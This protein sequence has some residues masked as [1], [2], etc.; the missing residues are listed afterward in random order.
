MVPCP[1]LPFSLFT[2]PSLTPCPSPSLYL[3][4]VPLPCMYAC[5]SVS[6]VFSLSLCLPPLSVSLSVLSPLFP[7]R[8]P[9]LL[10]HTSMSIGPL[11]KVCRHWLRGLCMMGDSCDFLHKMD[12][13]RMPLCRY[14]SYAD[15]CGF[16]LPCDP[17]CDGQG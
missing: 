8:P 1:S 2:F 12:R 17:R 13:N 6:Y 10:P 15:G 14:F 7:S 16:C 3:Y 11:L 5:S 4:D 9:S